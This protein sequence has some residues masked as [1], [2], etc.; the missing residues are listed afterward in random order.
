MK[1]KKPDYGDED[2]DELQLQ[3]KVVIILCIICFIVNIFH[4][5]IRFFIFELFGISINDY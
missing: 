2:E 3:L 4:Y 5:K 1:D